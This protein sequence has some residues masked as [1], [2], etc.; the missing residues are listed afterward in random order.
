MAGHR[1]WK[2]PPTPTTQAA[3][4]RGGAASL[5]EGVASCGVAAPPRL[6]ARRAG[7]PVSGRAPPLSRGVG[8]EGGEDGR[9]F[10][11][12]GCGRAAHAQGRTG[13]RSP[14]FLAL[15]PPPSPLPC[16]S[17]SLALPAPSRRRRRRLALRR[18]ARGAGAEG[19][20]VRP[21]P[22]APGPGAPPSAVRSRG[23]P[24]RSAAECP[25]SR[26]VSDRPV[27]ASR[28][29][30]PRRAARAPCALPA[31][32]GPG[33]RPFILGVRSF[34]PGRGACGSRR[35]R[36]GASPLP[37]FLASP[38]LPCSPAPRLPGSSVPRRLCS[39][40]PRPCP[41]ATLRFPGGHPEPTEG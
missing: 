33:L 9:G 6:S 24:R 27:V 22:P 25:I 29:L 26:R 28:P 20:P 10:T 12:R 16:T 2:D 1:H 37:C 13:P 5:R 34:R 11:L 18:S 23:R 40:G 38:L 7:P 15:P 3:A 21:P 31:R 41:R 36:A 35:P 4:S 32:P 19:L 17:G 39:P 14:H 8:E 30:A